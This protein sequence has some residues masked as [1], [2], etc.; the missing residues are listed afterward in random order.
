MESI[1]FTGII[2]A[3]RSPVF[4]GVLIDHRNP[5]FWKG[6]QT[7]P[8]YWQSNFFFFLKSPIFKILIPGKGVYCEWVMGGN[9][10]DP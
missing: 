6:V 10:F 5:K 2:Y 8:K 4:G 9:Y 7:Y 3:I 1:R